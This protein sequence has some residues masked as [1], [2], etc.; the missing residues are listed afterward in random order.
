MLFRSRVLFRSVAYDAAGKITNRSDIHRFITGASGKKAPAPC[1]F[2]HH[3]RQKPGEKELTKES[4]EEFEARL[5][6]RPDQ[7][8]EFTHLPIIKQ[9]RG[10]DRGYRRGKWCKLPTRC[11]KVPTTIPATRATRVTKGNSFAAMAGKSPNQQAVTV[12]PLACHAVKLSDT[13]MWGGNTG[14]AEK[15][16]MRTLLTAAGV[17]ISKK[18]ALVYGDVDINKAKTVEIE[19]GKDGV[20]LVNGVR[21]YTKIGVTFNTLFDENWTR[22][23]RF[24]NPEN[25]TWKL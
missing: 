18:E 8:R 7:P 15:K 4:D 9:G 1:M 11:P 13:D 6:F 16:R 22:Y 10:R 21:C 24:I 5:G 17:K 2:M 20:R 23:N 19:E 12:I 25:I 3:H 14:D